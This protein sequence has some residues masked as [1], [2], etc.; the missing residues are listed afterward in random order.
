M[1]D[2]AA[3]WVVWPVH[4][5]DG[6]IAAALL[7][8]G[9]GIVESNDSDMLHCPGIQ[10]MIFGFSMNGGGGMRGFVYPNDCTAQ[11]YRS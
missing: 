1:R 11:M 10:N 2:T 5:A 8:G 7:D 9:V 3:V 6:Q 4:D